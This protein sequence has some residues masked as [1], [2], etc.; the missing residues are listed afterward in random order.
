MHR[1][2][3]AADGRRPRFRAAWRTAQL[4]GITGAV[5]LFT[6]ALGAVHGPALG[7]VLIV[8]FAL[9]GLIDRVLLVDRPEHR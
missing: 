4:L 9:V 3:P 2:H 8:L 5:L 1:K 6:G 7:V